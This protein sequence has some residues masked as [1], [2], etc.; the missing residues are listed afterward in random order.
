MRVKNPMGGQMKPAGDG[1]SDDGRQRKTTRVVT[2]EAQRAIWMLL[3]LV[4][5]TTETLS[6]AM[7]VVVV[8]ERE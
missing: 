6:S 4:G 1:S 2:N 8:E 7:E 3:V 5:S